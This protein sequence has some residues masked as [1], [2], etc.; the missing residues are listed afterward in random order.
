MAPDMRQATELVAS[1]ALVDA[2]GGDR[3]P[4]VTDEA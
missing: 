1:G 3:L 4:L 2:A